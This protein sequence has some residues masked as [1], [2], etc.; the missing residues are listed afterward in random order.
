MDVKLKVGHLCTKA[1]E[2]ETRQKSISLPPK[3]G[4]LAPLH[5]GVANGTSKNVGLEKFGLRISKY[6]SK[7]FLI[8]LEVS[9]LHGLFYVF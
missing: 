7:A 1:G 4:E 9:F 5:L 8:S 6:I 2:R 3:A